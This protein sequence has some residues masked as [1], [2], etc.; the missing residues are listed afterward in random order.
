MSVR[1]RRLSS[2]T[3]T[4]FRRLGFTAATPATAWAATAH[5]FL[6]LDEP[7]IY[8]LPPDPVVTTRDLPAMWKR[9]AAAAAALAVAVAAS[10]LEGRH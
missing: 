9:A 3:G 4:G 8:G 7:E 1:D 2:S 10:F 5:F 6:L